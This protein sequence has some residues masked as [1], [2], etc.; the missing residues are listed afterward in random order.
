MFEFIKKLLFKFDDIADI[1]HY[2]LLQ[3]TSNMNES[4][5]ISFT[6]ESKDRIPHVLNKL[7]E[8]YG[9]NPDWKWIFQELDN[10]CNMHPQERN[11]CWDLKGIE[12]SENFNSFFYR[13]I[14]MTAVFD[15]VEQSK[16]DDGVDN[17]FYVILYKTCLE[18][19]GLKPFVSFT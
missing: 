18:K 4:E 1:V 8:L 11:N 12:N 13:Y 19:V 15:Y 10:L 2:T 16:G 5:K 7:S 9:E 6:F 14:L 17:K 3:V